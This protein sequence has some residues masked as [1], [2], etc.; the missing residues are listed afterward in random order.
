MADSPNVGYG[1]ADDPEPP[2]PPKPAERA[3]DARPKPP[4]PTVPRK[5]KEADAAPPAKP[6][7]WEAFRTY[8]TTPPAKKLKPWEV[9]VITV[10]IALLL[11]VAGGMAY[12]QRKGDSAETA[13][14]AAEMTKL[15]APPAAGPARPSPGKVAILDTGTREPHYLHRCLQSDLRAETPQEA[16]A[17]VQLRV[18]DREVFEY[19]NGRKA[20]N[21]T[22]HLT[23][24]DK[25]TWAKIDEKAFECGDPPDSVRLKGGDRSAVTGSLPVK[26]MDAYLRGLF[27]S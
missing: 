12:W 6:N 19:L 13:A 16:V 7:A 3:R 20:V 4:K 23:V 15:M 14:F 22:F 24:I 8:V 21:R 18:A 5:P 9:V 25:A 10:V 11:G 1:F 17:V 27:G 26:E 2:R